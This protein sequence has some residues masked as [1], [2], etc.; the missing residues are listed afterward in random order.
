[1]TRW[2]IRRSAGLLLLAVA[3]LCAAPETRAQRPLL[4]PDAAPRAPR[5]VRYDVATAKAHARA[6]VPPAAYAD[7]FAYP[8]PVADPVEQ[9]DA[10]PD[11]APLEKRFGAENRLLVTNTSNYPWRTICKLEITFPKAKLPGTGAII[12]SQYVLTAG[13][14]VFNPKYG[15]WALSVKVIPGLNGTATPPFGS[16]RAD[17]MQTFW[18]WTEDNNPDYDMAL[19][20]LDAPLGDSTGWM[21]H[22]VFS[23][24]DGAWAYVSGYPTDLPSKTSPLRGKRQYWDSG[25]LTFF[26]GDQESVYY[27]MDTGIGQSG[28]PVF[29]AIG[30]KY[31]ILAV[32]AGEVASGE[33]NL[34]TRIT[35][36]KFNRIHSWIAAAE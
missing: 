2:F 27:Q 26:E 28:A 33:F 32:H 4:S 30:G 6:D 31:Y 1:M 24:L 12:D 19:I 10:L 29:R 9:V 16:A 25:A 17:W 35:S 20:A 21:G 5:S 18:E 34:A 11:T 23:D 8:S 3:C 7:D 22:G 15:G 13:H 36:G 14:C